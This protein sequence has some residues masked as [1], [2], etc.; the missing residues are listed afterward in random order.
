MTPLRLYCPKCG[1]DRSGLAESPCPECGCRL[2]PVDVMGPTSSV[3]PTIQFACAI[4][5]F[6]L[7]ALL[8]LGSA[9][10]AFLEGS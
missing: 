7:P 5:I 8:F 2:S 3:P 6:L 9:L 10:L 1:Y 4:A